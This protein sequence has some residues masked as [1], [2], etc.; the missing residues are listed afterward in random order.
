MVLDGDIAAS[1]LKT[2]MNNKVDL[3]DNKT[4]TIVSVVL[5]TGV[6]G[7]FLFNASFTGVSLAM[8]L[9]VILNAILKEK[10]IK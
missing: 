10:K 4:L 8:I 5:C 2:L 7:I 1:G 6:G 3:E 9:G